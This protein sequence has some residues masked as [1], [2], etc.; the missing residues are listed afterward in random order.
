M[1]NQFILV[2]KLCKV[3]FFIDVQ[4]IA[5]TFTTCKPFSNTHSRRTSHLFAAIGECQENIAIKSIDYEMDRSL[6]LPSWLSVVHWEVTVKKGIIIYKSR[7][8]IFFALLN[9]HIAAL[10]CKFCAS[11]CFIIFCA[12]LKLCFVPL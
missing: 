4:V 10:Q 9:K 8:F 12:F 1:R 5:N 6:A 11:L 3:S 2:G 7:S